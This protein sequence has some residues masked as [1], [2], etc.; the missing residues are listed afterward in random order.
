MNNLFNRINFKSVLVRLTISIITTFAGQFG[1]AC[2]YAA[3]LGTDPISV[4]IDG[5]HSFSGLSYGTISTINFVILTALILIFER[6]HFGIAAV[7][8]VFIGGPI[9][10]GSLA[11]L[12][13]YFPT[14][15]TQLWVRIIILALG[16]VVFAIATGISIGCN[17][18]IGCFSFPP[19]WL[20]DLTKIDIKWTQMI[21]D[22]MFLITG[23]ILKGV[24]GIGTIVGI[25][26][27][28]PILAPF[29][30]ITEKFCNKFGPMIN[31]KHQ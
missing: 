9:L 21:T 1:V 16:A 22:A 8:N 3:G 27:T 4:F 24:I 23:V 7:V 25:L 6:K 10:D 18:G 19:I 29:I 26:V 17:A 30:P 31:E 28:G 2:Y 15:T 11:I 5:L 14:E 12:N 13:R 20:S